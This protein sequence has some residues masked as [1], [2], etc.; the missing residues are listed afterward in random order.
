MT[1]Q[2]DPLVVEARIAAIVRA[3]RIVVDLMN[4]ASAGYARRNMANRAAMVSPDV[5]WN[6]CAARQMPIRTGRPAAAAAA[7]RGDG[8]RGDQ[9]CARLHKALN[10]L[11]SGMAEPPRAGS[12]TIG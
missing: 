1:V 2:L 8:F 7:A 12:A 5:A 11:S 6:E 3:G 9:S 10:P 4:L